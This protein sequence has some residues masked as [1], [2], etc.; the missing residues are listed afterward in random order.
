MGILK[1]TEFFGRKIRIGHFSSR[2]QAFLFLAYSIMY[3]LRITQGMYHYFCIVG[4]SIGKHG[5]L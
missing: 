2:M 4:V 3:K 5:K 1:T